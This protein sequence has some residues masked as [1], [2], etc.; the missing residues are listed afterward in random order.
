[1]DIALLDDDQDAADLVKLWLTEAGHRV[2]HFADGEALLAAATGRGHDLYLLDWLVP[3]LN[4]IGVLLRLRAAG[5]ARPVLFLSAMDAPEEADDAL[6]AGADGFLA[7]PVTREA[8]LD[9][10][11]ALRRLG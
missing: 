5:V 10:I 7:K 4:G 2:E 8:L 1:M 9:R 11:E 6:R 3:G